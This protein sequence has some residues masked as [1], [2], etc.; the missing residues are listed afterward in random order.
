MIDRDH[1]LPISKQA[2]VLDIARSTVYYKPHGLS[3]K[4]IALMKAID[5]IHTEQPFKGARRIAD[6]LAH[7]GHCVGRRH[8]GTLMKAM[9]IEA[10]CPKP[11]TSKA[12]PG[13]AVFP[14]LLRHRAIT[15]ANDVWTMDTTYI[16]MAQGFVY[17][18]AVKDVHSRAVLSH[19]VATTLEASVAVEALQEAIHRFGAPNIVNTD[20][21]SQFTAQA[22]V[23]CVQRSGA[24]L[25]MDGKG[26]WRDNVFIER[27]WWTVKYERIYLTTYDTVVQAREDIARYIDWFNTKREHSSIEKKTPMQYYFET[28]PNLAK[29]A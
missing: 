21:G 19:R 23:D 2:R 10:L 12:R 7:Q 22:F 1:P 26:A 20:Q 13:H 4:D 14:Y 27:F 28:L 5:R 17:L 6:D 8:V 24:K 11:G 3:L 9:D 15:H 25:S 29:A 18:T 16:P